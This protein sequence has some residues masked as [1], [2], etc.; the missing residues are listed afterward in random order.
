[1]RRRWRVALAGAGLLAAL[2]AVPVATIELGCRAPIAGFDPHVPYRSIAEAERPEARTWLTYP[3]WHIVYAAESLG[4]WLSA[5]LP[6]SGYGYAGDIAGFWTGFCRINRVARSRPGA[7]DAKVMIYSIGI[8]FTLEMAVKAAYER[9]IGRLSEWIG[10]WD[11]GDDRYAA[12]AQ[13]RYGAFMHETPWYRFPF[14]ATLRG[15]W[16]TRAG[17]STVRHVERRVALTAEYVVKSGYAK[18]IRSADAAV[19][20]PDRRMLRFVARAEPNAIRRVDERLRPLRSAGGV[21]VVAAPRYAQFTD[22]IGKL[23]RARI[24]LVE[25]A[26]NDDIFVTALLPLGRDVPGTVLLDQPLEQAGWRRIGTSVKV[27]GL[28]ALVEAVTEAGG[29]IEHVYDY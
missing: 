26:G 22:L 18:A 21:T 5:G 12:M 29:R 27:P 24:P 3:E 6:P 13:A 17:T 16:K 9:T 14:D 8:S 2:V 19:S 10:G 23:A 1:M 25:V 11:S 15:A 7:G 28:N 4:R 20:A